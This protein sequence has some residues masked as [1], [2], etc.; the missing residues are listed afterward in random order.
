MGKVSYKRIH[1]CKEYFASLGTIRHRALFGGYSL[2]IDD[3][4][5]AMVSN[6]ELYLRACEQT[7]GYYTTNSRRLLTLNKRGRPVSLNYYLVDE[8]L[9]RDRSLL[10]KMSE[11][12]LQ[13]AQ[14]EKIRRGDPRRLKN[15]PNITFQLELLLSEAG[16]QDLEML[17]ALGAVAAWLR[18]RR[19]R[20]DLSINVLFALEGAIQGIHATRI[21]LLRRQHLQ[22][23]AERLLD[24]SKT[25]LTEE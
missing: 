23:L 3:T 17:Q 4:V 1:Q 24:K 16:V 19:I 21:P 9:W 11:M 14:S 13:G 20:K 7:T 6:G 18:L 22:E 2:S 25:K 15:S 5:F 10:L 12:S 8:V